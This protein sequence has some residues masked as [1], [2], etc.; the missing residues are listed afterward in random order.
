[1]KILHVLQNY[2]PSKGGTQLLFKEV[3][4]ILVSDYGDEVTVATTNSLY[5]P[6]SN[7][8][9]KLARYDCINGVEIRRFPFWN[10]HRNL[11]K[12]IIQII[13]KIRGKRLSLFNPLLRVPLSGKMRR[14]IEQYEAEV[15]CGSSSNYMYMDYACERFRKNA[16]KPFVFMGAIH[17]DNEYN[18]QVPE[19][20]LA[21]IRCADKYIANTDFEKKCLV[22][23]GIPTDKIN[24]I[25][26]GVHPRV[27]TGRSKQRA[28][29]KFGVPEYAF[30]IGYV[31]RFAAS[32]GIETLLK[33][34]AQ[35]A[36]NECVLLLAGAANDYFGELMERIEAEY[37]GIRSKIIILS[38]FAEEDKPDIYAAMDVFV[39]ASYS[40]S[41]GI[42]FLEA[43]SAGLPVVGINIGAIRCVIDD[44]VNGRLFRPH[45]HKE[46]IDIL[47]YYRQNPEVGKQHGL[48]GQKKVNQRYTWEY[49]AKAYRSTY[50]EAIAIHRQ[51][52]CAA[53]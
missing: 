22:Q 33:A 47:R 8:F 18:I 17:F 30:V 21:N 49:I 28:R 3:S 51:K 26:C 11:I 48:E 9:S 10:F 24:V 35:I 46:L 13:Y 6:G 2:E 37:R 15:V 40:E 50:E 32:K 27:F 12:Y 45:E 19:P 34:F 53:S 39:S 16:A 1:M 43:W 31:G 23:L 44:G 4:E 38:D 20:V 52:S 42:V 41:F 29:K 7:Y 14:F 5:D 25:G 36:D